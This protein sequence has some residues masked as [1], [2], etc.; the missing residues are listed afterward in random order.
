MDHDVKQYADTLYESARMESARTLR[1][2][3]VELQRGMAARN[4]GNLPLSGIEIQAVIRLYVAH[5]DRCTTSRFESY[6]QA[7]AET[8]RM[9]SEQDFVDITNEFKA[10]RVQEIGHSARAIGE[11]IAS[12]GPITA[13][14]G[15]PGESVDHGSAENHDRVLGMLKIWR[16]KERLKLSPRIGNEE[17]VSADHGVD[18]VDRVLPIKEKPKRPGNWWQRLTPDGKAATT[19]GLVAL[20]V[21]ILAVPGVNEH[22]HF[23]KESRVA[24]PKQQAPIEPKKDDRTKTL[25]IATIPPNAA[26][27]ESLGPEYEYKVAYPPILIKRVAAIY[28]PTALKAGIEGRV[29]LNVYI[30]KDGT[31][32]KVDAWM[33]NPVFIEAAKAAVKKWKYNPYIENGEA[34]KVLT[35]ATIEFRLPN[36]REPR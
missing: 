3:R 24:E 19:I 34:K 28:P 13:S 21:G 2:A 14:A 5:V 10:V 20:V 12:R 8:G 16:A 25:P 33:G 35:T 31:V 30:G 7:Y 1:D 15:S 27:L 9:P 22:L 29:E 36:G 23:K 11:F 17:S 6:Q 32:D 4:S 26:L 18:D